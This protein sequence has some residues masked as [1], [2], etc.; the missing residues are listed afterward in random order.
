VPYSPNFQG[1]GKSGSRSD[2]Y[3]TVK[4][5]VSFQSQFEGSQRVAAG[6]AWRQWAPDRDYHLSKTYI[7]DNL[8]DF[9]GWEPNFILD[10]AC[11]CTA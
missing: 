9:K 5:Q 2:V 7:T 1:G 4:C 3:A 10:I 8:N 11:K 6:D